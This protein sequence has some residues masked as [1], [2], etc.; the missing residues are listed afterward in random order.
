MSTVA[1]Y[2][3]VRFAPSA[4]QGRGHS[5]GPHLRSFAVLEASYSVA[6]RGVATRRG[7]RQRRAECGLG[8]VRPRARRS[9]NC[10]CSRELLAANSRMVNTDSR[11]AHSGTL[12]AVLSNSDVGALTFQPKNA[13]NLGRFKKVSTP[14]PIGFLGQTMRPFQT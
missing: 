6:G 4:R 14:Q 13:Q 2:D 8:A 12:A 1:L 7:C 5:I 10:A 3:N 9:Y 11:W